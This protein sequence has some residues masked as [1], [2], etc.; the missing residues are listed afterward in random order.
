[1]VVLKGAEGAPEF[2][3]KCKYWVKE[4]NETVEYVI[5]PADYGIHYDKT[6]ENMSLQEALEEINNPSVDLENL[7][8]LNAAFYLVVA[9]KANN[10]QE[11]YSLIK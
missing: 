4:N 3:E 8:K 11:A 6:F 7:A 9:Q 1:M 10:I 2:F 5:D